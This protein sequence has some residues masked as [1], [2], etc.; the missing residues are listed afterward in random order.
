[1]RSPSPLPGVTGFACFRDGVA[2]ADNEALKHLC[3]ELATPPRLHWV[4]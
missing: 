2:L 4:F 3:R 1:M